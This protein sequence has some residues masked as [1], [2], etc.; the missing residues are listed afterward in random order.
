M[1]WSSACYTE[2]RVLGLISLHRFPPL[3]LNPESATN[4]IV[5]FGAIRKDLSSHN[6]TW[7]SQHD[8]DFDLKTP[9]GLDHAVKFWC[10]TI[11]LRVGIEERP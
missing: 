4:I 7:F 6:V 3:L 8:R 5:E 10:F 9:I 2:A 11:D 1:A